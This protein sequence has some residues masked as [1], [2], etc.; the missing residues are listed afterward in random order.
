MSSGQTDLL[1][2]NSTRHCGKST[3]TPPG[4]SRDPNSPLHQSTNRNIKQQINPSNSK[5]YFFSTIW[6]S[7]FFLLAYVKSNGGLS[8]CFS[9][10]PCKSSCISKFMHSPLESHMAAVYRIL[11]YLK[12]T[13]GRGLF[14]KKMTIPA[15]K[16]LQTLIGPD[17]LMIESLLQVIGLSYLGI[18]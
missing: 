8:H 3:H 18:W 15:L 5:Y 10:K 11:Q 1:C 7:F 9:S 4:Y 2:S 16:S 14:L 13:P 17:L 12:S 6:L